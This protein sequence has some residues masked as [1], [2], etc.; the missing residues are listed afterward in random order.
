MIGALNNNASLTQDPATGAWTPSGDIT[1]VA[2]VVLGLKAGIAREQMTQ[3]PA[4]PFALVQEYPFDS[5]IKRMSTV[6][7]A[8]EEPD[9]LMVYTKGSVESLLA[10]SSTVATP[11]GP[12]PL[13]A[14]QRAKIDL[15]MTSIA[16]QGLRVLALAARR[17]P[18]A[19]EGELR[20]RS[21]K[22]TRAL[23]EAEL[24]FV[25]LVGIM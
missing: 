22:E 5:S 2:L 17:L 7:A 9:S 18:R 24:E 14:V 25:G 10:L 3:G 1:E 16:S 6:F 19:M 21:M 8:A 23:V 13:D 15:I 11:A 4:A 12:A 20:G